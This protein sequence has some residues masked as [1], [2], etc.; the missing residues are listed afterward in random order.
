MYEPNITYVNMTFILW[1]NKSDLS[2]HEHAIMSIMLLTMS[3]LAPYTFAD[4]Y[5]KTAI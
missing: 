5:N 2:L 4:H 3:P 1:F